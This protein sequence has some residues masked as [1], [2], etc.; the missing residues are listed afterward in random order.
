MLLDPRQSTATRRLRVERSN[1]EWVINGDTWADVV[2]SGYERTFAKVAPDAVETWEVE[3]SSGGWFHP[4]HVHL[5]DFQ[6]LSRNGAAPFPWERG[7]KDVVY[8]G[9]GETVRL[10]MR[11]SHGEGR[12]MIH[13][14]NNAHEDHDMMVQYQVG[15]HSAD[16]DSI[17]TDPPRP[18]PWP[19]LP[20]EDGAPTAAPTTTTPTTTTPTTTAPRTTTA[21][22]TTT[23]PRTTAPTPTKPRGRR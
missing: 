19:P 7:P 16:C 20:G 6:V 9:E 18:G 21:P 15:E 23:P 11:F 12:Y 13:C 1:G 4:V 8:V 2:D 5:V 14:H 10:L 3:N 22:T 17:A